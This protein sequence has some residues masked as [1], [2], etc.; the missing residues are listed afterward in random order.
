MKSD[1]VSLHT[2]TTYSYGDGYGQPEDFV[3]RA[4]E[5]GH[6]A[7]AFTEHGNISSHVKAEIACDASKSADWPGQVKGIYGCELYTRDTPSK[8]KYHMVVLAQNQDGYRDLLT[9]VSASW[10]NF[11]YFPTATSGMLTKYGDNLIVLSGC[12]G[13][14]LA[15]KSIGGKDIE[16]GGGLPAAL[17]IAAMMREKFGDRYYLEVQAFPELNNAKKYNQ[18]LVEV[19]TRLG[20]P[21]VVTLDAHYPRPEHMPMHSLIHAIARG[22]S[23][24]KNT[25]D[26]QEQG[27]DYNVPMTLFSRQDVG[28]RLHS[29]G[30]D[31]RLLVSHA[32][33]ST[34]EIAQRC[35]VILPKT[36]LVKYP[37]PPGIKDAEELCWQWLREGWKYRHISSNLAPGTTVDDY[38]ARLK[39]EMATITELGFI[40][41]FLLYSDMVRWAK[42]QGILV[43]PARGSAA[44]SLVC[45]LLRICEVEPMRYP[46]MIFERFIN[47]SR[48]D[49]PD[50]D[51]D[52]DDERRSEIRDYLVSKYGAD[53]VGNIGTFTKWR[54]KNAIDDVARVTGVPVY[55]TSRLKEFIIERSSG[56]SRFSKTLEDTVDQFPAAKEIM[57]RNPSLRRAF[58]LEGML[59]GF[60]VHAA[61]LVVGNTPLT[62][63]CAM[64]TREIKAKYAGGRTRHLS[65]LSVDKKDAEY[66]GIMKLDI[67]GLKT[68]GMLNDCLKMTGMTLDDL[69]TLPLDDEPT[70]DGFRRGDVKGIFQF[71]GRTTRS[72]VS[73]LKPDNF[74]ELIDI[75]ALSR[76]GPYHSGTTLDYINQKWGSWNRTDDRN[77]WTYNETIERLC[78][79]TKYQIIYQEQ[80]LAICREIGNF[81]WFVSHEIRRIVSLKYGEAAF[82]ARR[83][84]FIEGA[85]SNGVDEDTADL[86]FKRLVT[87][88]QYAFVLAHSIS[89]TMIGYWAMW[90]KVHY[91]KAFYAAQ[92]RKNPK[93]R[94]PMFMR[95][96]D[97][98]KFMDKRGDGSRILVGPLDIETSGITWSLTPGGMIVPGFSQIPGIGLK[99][100]AEIV[101]DR[102]V[103]EEIAVNKQLP[104]TDWDWNDL[105]GV[106]GIGPVKLGVIKDW[107]TR[108]DPF[109]VAYLHNKLDEVRAMLRSGELVD[110]AGRMLPATTHKS[111]DLP[112]DLG[113][114]F[115]DAQGN[116]LWDAEK[117]TRFDV[118]WIGRVKGR[119][120][121]DIFEEHR[122]REGV[123]LDPSTIREPDKKHSMVLFAYDDSDEINLRVSRWNYPRMKDLLM[124][125]NLDHD[126]VLV[127]GFKNRSFGRKI[128]VLDMWL[129]DPD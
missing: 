31:D 9:L 108:K 115:Y 16:H 101:A 1:F 121:R 37:L 35:N 59:K 52:F 6:P 82:N 58:A 80:I 114:N 126:L 50:I 94:W 25:V 93:E 99:M 47:P 86:I 20:I 65:V 109:G 29:A 113:V 68:L 38:V 98:H 92:L 7:I 48:T 77:R 83:G 112:L 32:L 39:S 5:L 74:Q 71:E 70:I 57:D 84:L 103:S 85:L 21:L 40:D 76:P 69:Y 111:E 79:Y 53:H 64:Y 17:R 66:T 28:Q 81:S 46:H 13:S 122:S 10:A 60:G 41:Y 118:T 127:K 19:H 26:Q 91:P 24:G 117:D 129:I 43:G 75:N 119:N 14:A 33:D 102:M 4:G 97:D 90:F 12:L 45:Y 18:L 23:A 15:V 3:I 88:G 61:G 72:I 100:A 54:G 95:D 87:A 106:R 107:A 22:G 49:P 56:D 27:W 104:G 89:Y 8:H 63:T 96:M 62:D 78:G 67:L 34:L 128:E 2:H 11:Y 124:K 44:A 110:V 36:P 73:Q 120:L 116:A 42:G 123:D 55:E 51:L 105:A 30:V 125:I